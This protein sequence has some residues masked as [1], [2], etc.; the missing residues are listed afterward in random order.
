[1]KYILSLFFTLC[2]FSV[3][4]QSPLLSF[5]AAFYAPESADAVCF[6]KWKPF[7]FFSLYTGN[8]SFGGLWT[9]FS[10]PVPSADS[11]LKQ[12]EQGRSA[13]NI[14]GAAEGIFP[15]YCAAETAFPG[16]WFTAFAGCE[17]GQLSPEKKQSIS[18]GENPEYRLQAGAGLVFPFTVK[19]TLYTKKAEAEGYWALAW[20]R[21][22]IDA[23][24]ST[25]WFIRQP[26]FKS[27]YTQTLIQSF[28]I[29]GKTFRFAA[30]NGWSENPYGKPA[31]FISG[32]IFQ[33][34]D[35]FLY[36][37]GFFWCSN[38]YLKQNGSFEKKRIQFF[39]NPQLTFMLPFAF[40]DTVRCGTIAEVFYTKEW[41]M[42]TRAALALQ[43]KRFSF[44]TDVQFPT[45]GF[46]DIKEKALPVLQKPADC[47]LK[48]KLNFFQNYGDFFK[49]KWTAG[50]TCTFAMSGSVSQPV[51]TYGFNTGFKASFKIKNS[52]RCTASLSAQTNLPAKKTHIKTGIGAEP[53]LRL[54]DKPRF[55]SGVNAEFLLKRGVLQKAE[56]R[57]HF[58]I[59]YN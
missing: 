29:K 24:Q 43:G 25:S 55:S 39:L 44:N 36:H 48:T 52:L 3:P 34:T 40:P 1:M 30:E 26:P 53:A 22:Y 23:P 32:K 47:I 5:A 54:K 27:F 18:Q 46:T 9:S 58:K 13:F 45:V 35:V 33:T 11:A 17:K 6:V 14:Q 19:K 42:E 7:P 50:G 41:I 37:A 10:S 16:G 56:Y 51:K 15:L 31:F 8:L 2:A 4:A 12:R 49:S 20:K 28:M 59:R 38:D 21:V 57:V